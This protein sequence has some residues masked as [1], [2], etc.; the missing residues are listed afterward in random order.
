[1]AL[2]E[3][4]IPLNEIPA[5]RPPVGQVSHIHNAVGRTHMITTCDI[6]CIIIV[7]TVVAMRFYTRVRLL[8]SLWWDDWCTLFALACWLGETGLFQ[9]ACK[10]GAGKHIYD[11]TVADLYPNLLRGW[12]V[13]AIMYSITMLFSKMS[14]L[15]LYRRVF[16]INNFAKRWWAVVAFTVAYSLGAIFASLFQCRPMESA[17]SIDITPEY[18][19]ST[20][21]FYTAN[22]ALNVVSDILILLLPVPIV[23]GLNTDVRKKV[24]LTGLFSMGSISC[25]VSIL[26]MRSIIVLYK[27]GY[28]DLTW[29]LVEVVLWSQAELTAAM[30]CTCTPCLR[31]LFEKIIPALR[32][33]TSRKGTHGSSTGGYIRTGDSGHKSS[34]SKSKS[35]SDIEMD[36]GIR[37][38]VTVDVSALGSD[39]DSQKSIIRHQ[40]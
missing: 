30:I 25:L 36:A 33:A 9:Y 7:C 40:A 26:R 32:S 13:C 6:I 35:I 29:G 12:V 34:V 5:G 10:F 23:W 16:P 39:S 17:W 22:A 28:S 37:K 1:M 24:I 21:K 14:I 27:S 8:K 38:K 31:P 15:L 4:G 19:I 2:V 20:E 18:C 3:S 11:I